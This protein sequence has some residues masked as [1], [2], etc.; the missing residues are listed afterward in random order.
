M[1]LG[2]GMGREPATGKLVR[3]LLNE[4]S[5]P[6][7]M[8]AD[9]LYHVSKN[10]LINKKTA[11][12]ITPHTGEFARLMNIGTEDVREAPIERALELARDTNTIVHLKD[13]TSLTALPSGR[14][15][16]RHRRTRHGHR[17]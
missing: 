15:H 16:P 14:V 5:I 17:R 10:D 8:D 13:S 7:V 11:L 9:A 3:A 12:I 6:L 1:V 2:P 4:A